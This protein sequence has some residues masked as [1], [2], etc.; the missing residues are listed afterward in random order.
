MS[1]SPGPQLEHG[2][3]RIAN[4]LLEQLAKRLTHSGAMLAVMLLVIRFSY[5]FNRKM[6]HFTMT[7]ISTKLGIDRKNTRRAVL[8]LQA[9]NMLTVT[10]R[11]G[12]QRKRYQVN[13]DWRR[14]L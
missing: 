12:H 14:W 11:P 3:T 13:K 2:H 7:E 4:E 9:L 8:A 6:A 10:D 5:G 1:R